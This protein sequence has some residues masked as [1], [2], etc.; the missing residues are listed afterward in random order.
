MVVFCSGVIVV[1]VLVVVGSDA[2]VLAVMLVVVL[3]IHAS[4]TGH[5]AGGVGSV[6][7]VASLENR[8]RGSVGLEP[9]REMAVT[10]E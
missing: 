8:L 2:V 4:G 10:C 6:V 1:V 7:I 5:C 9:E 3:V